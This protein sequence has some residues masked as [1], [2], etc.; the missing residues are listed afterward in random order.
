MRGRGWVRDIISH[1]VIV[2]LLGVGLFLLRKKAMNAPELKDAGWVSTVFTIAF[3]L[4]I[5][6]V[7]VF[8]RQVFT[9]VR[10]ERFRP[11]N[12]DSLARLD[13]MRRFHLP[14]RFRKLQE[15]WHGARREICQFYEDKGWQPV[16]RKPFDAVLQRRRKFPSFGRPPSV[17]RLF[18]FY[19]PMLNV[20]IVDQILNMCERLIRRSYGSTPAPRNMIVFLTDMKNEEEVTSAA[21]GVVNYLCRLE[22]K[23]SLYPLLIDFNGGRLYYPIDTTLA[24]K[25]HRLFFF[26]ARLNLMRFVRRQ[27]PK[28]IPGNEPADET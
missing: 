5:L 9:C 20:L 28:K 11:G 2:S 8:F 3:I 25:L 6:M 19:H 1:F 26:K 14:A 24:R 22:K 13:R 10:L 18:V 12:P 4:F 16:E 27:V 23:M 15:K 21:A 17:D 7:V